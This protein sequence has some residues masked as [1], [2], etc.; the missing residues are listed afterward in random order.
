MGVYAPRYFK[1]GSS[2]KIHT[3]LNQ[4]SSAASLSDS[5]VVYIA[6]LIFKQT[7]SPPICHLKGCLGDTIPFCTHVSHPNCIHLHKQVHPEPIHPINSWH[8]N[9]EFVAIQS[10][11]PLTIPF[12]HLWTSINYRISSTLCSNCFCQHST[13]KEFASACINHRTNL[14]K[15]Y[16][17]HLKHSI[18]KHDICEC[19]KWLHTPSSCRNISI[20]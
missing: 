1:D 2:D 11:E 17:N 19:W 15:L 20:I 3:C 13:H 6:V 5:A 9:K 16:K 8:Q 4:L 7:H 12:V 14:R 10:A 18:P